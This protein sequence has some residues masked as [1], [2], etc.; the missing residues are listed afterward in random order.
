M[1]TNDG[2]Q[3][4]STG[5]GTKG[6]S[7]ETEAEGAAGVQTGAPS[8]SRPSNAQTQPEPGP[9]SHEGGHL[10]GEDQPVHYHVPERWL[11]EERCG[12]HQQGVKPGRN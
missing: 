12:E 4:P 9:S 6:R 1:E 8:A 7:A 5:P 11:P 2:G 10:P 3:T